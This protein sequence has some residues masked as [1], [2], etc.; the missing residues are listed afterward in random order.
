MA[1]LKLHAAEKPCRNQIE[2]SIFKIKGEN[3]VRQV[4]GLLKTLVQACGTVSCNN[5]PVVPD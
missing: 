2:G 5:C 3:G 4:L 1:K